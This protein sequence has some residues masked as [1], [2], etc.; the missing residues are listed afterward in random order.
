MDRAELILEIE[1]CFDRIHCLKLLRYATQ[2]N[3][4]VFE[5]RDG[6]RINLDRLSDNE[7]NGLRNFVVDILDVIIETDR[8]DKLASG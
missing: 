7:Y 3:L 4:P 1:R 2:N 6:C 8:Q 5:H